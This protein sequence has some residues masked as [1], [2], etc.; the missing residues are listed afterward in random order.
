MKSLKELSKQKKKIKKKMPEFKRQES[1]RRKRLGTK[2]R[3]PR[4]VQSK[5]RLR[6]RGKPKMVSIGFKTISILRHANEEGKTPFRVENHNDLKNFNPE[7]NFAIL[8]S[9]IGSKKRLEILEKAKSKKISFSNIR[10]LDSEIRKIKESYEKRKKQKKEKAEKK[11]KRQEELKKKDKEVADI[12]KKKKIDEKKKQEILSKIKKAAK[13]TAPNKE[14]KSDI[15]PGE[16]ST[17]VGPFSRRTVAKET[18]PNKE[19][20]QTKESESKKP[21]TKNKP[22]TQDSKKENN[23]K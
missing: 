15:E 3:K 21:E 10:N 7:K 9:K 20:K 22:K 23:K 11:K 18:A 1:H 17:A 8:S 16:D 12:K 19:N 14:N 13:E 2:W 5:L 4:G 6:R